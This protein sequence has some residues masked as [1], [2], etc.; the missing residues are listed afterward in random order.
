M[1]G[2]ETVK[3]VQERD[4]RLQR[5][6]LGDGGEVLGFLDRAGGEQRPACLADGHHIL[7]VAVNGQGMGRDGACSNMEDRAG[8]FAGD[9]VHV[10]DHQQQALGGGEGGGEGAGLKGAVHGSC[11]AAFGLHFDHE[12]DCAPEI[13]L[14]FG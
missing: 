1:G 13:F 7:V 6:R 14:A 2:A 11:R 8:Q 10:G 4:A 5:R 9:L 3:E 12:G